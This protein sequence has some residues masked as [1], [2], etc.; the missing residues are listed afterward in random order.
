MLTGAGHQMVQAKPGFAVGE[1]TAPKDLFETVARRNGPLPNYHPQMLLQCLLWGKFKPFSHEQKLKP[2]KRKTG[3]RQAY[4]CT[5]GSGYEV[6]NTRR[7]GII[8]TGIITC[9][10]IF[11]Y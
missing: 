3:P 11:R 5:T 6:F 10:R 7:E 1:N 8:R 2:L 9:G 4:H